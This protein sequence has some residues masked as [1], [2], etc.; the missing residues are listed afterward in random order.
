[1]PAAASQ[2]LAYGQNL[3]PAKSAITV[4]PPAT[5]ASTL[6][7]V[8]T[9]I[10]PAETALQS[11]SYPPPSS[12]GASNP[13]RL[14]LMSESTLPEQEPNDSA[15][16]AQPVALPAHILGRFGSNGD[17]DWYTFSAKKSER[18]WIEITSQ[19]LGLPTDP[20]FLIQHLTISDKGQPLA[21][22]IA[23]ADDQSRAQDTVDPRRQF[24]NDDP[25][26]LFTAPDDG[27]YRLL[28]RDLYATP[29]AEPRYCYVLTIRP[30]KPDFSLMMLTGMTDPNNNPQ[31]LPGG[32]LLRRGGSLPIDVIALRREG[33]DGEIRVSAESLPPD[34]TASPA[35]IGPWSD[36]TSLVLQAANDVALTLPPIASLSVQGRANIAG[37][38][39]VRPAR[40][41]EAMGL[42]QDGD[43]RATVRAVHEIPLVLR[44]DVTPPCSISAGSANGEPIRMARGGKLQVPVRIT[45][46]G[47]FK[48]AVSMAAVG[49]HAQLRAA[50]FTMEAGKTEQTLDIDVDPS[51][52]SGSF[53]FILRADP[54]VKYVRSP[55]LARQAAEDLKRISQ[56]VEEA[57][58]GGE[59]AKQALLD[60]EQA[61]QRAEQRASETKLRA[62]P[63]ESR[64]LI[65]C[66]P[67]AIQIVD[68]P[69]TLTFTPL[70]LKAGAAVP[71]SFTVSAAKHFGFDDDIRF[72]FLPLDDSTYVS[73]ND[74]SNVLA[75]A[76]MQAPL[77]A[78]AAT[79][80]KPGAHAFRLRAEYRFNNRDLSVEVPI[81]VTISPPD[82]KP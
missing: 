61:R 12:R 32:A 79:N 78:R 17:R 7:A 39:V 71:V 74:K 6:A 73:F 18:L 9:L 11:F 46:N 1:M 36:S 30:P 52:P 55:E 70:T 21:L 34:V 2:H 58:K 27:S 25:A 44:D 40:P 23:T 22:D 63:K 66:Q 77:S 42:L 54:L 53:T 59:P 31:T 68:A 16:N 37:A 3:P 81:E 10:R 14:T 28:V 75:K 51:A 60:A 13:I 45:R 80:A 33:F 35:I 57:R 72:Q 24:S 47:D 67:V 20:A 8:A 15:E 64:L 38:E 49:L 48:D 19:R 26:V 65:A 41:M 56:L 69:F 50:Q 76:Q 62:D 82:A 5:T 29:H 43:I 4:T